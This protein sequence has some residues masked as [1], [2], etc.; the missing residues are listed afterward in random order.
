[1]NEALTFLGVG[2]AWGGQPSRSCEGAARER[3]GHTDQPDAQA[4]GIF[5]GNLLLSLFSPFAINLQFVTY[6]VNKGSRL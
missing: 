5:N 4:G 2:A 3:P 6:C 1:M